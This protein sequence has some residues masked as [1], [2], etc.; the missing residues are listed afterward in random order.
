MNF[1]W[2]HLILA[3]LLGVGIALSVAYYLVKKYLKKQM[4][5]VKNL[6]NKEQIQHLSEA[7]GRKLPD[8]KINQILKNLEESSANF[9]EEKSNKKTKNK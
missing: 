2:G 8:S 9:S 3:F 7:F 5:S 4:N 6:M 1:N